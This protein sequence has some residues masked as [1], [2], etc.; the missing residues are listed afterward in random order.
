MSQIDELKK[1]NEA[2]KTHLTMYRKMLNENLAISK[3][4]QQAPP[5][6][7]EQTKTEHIRGKTMTNLDLLAQQSRLNRGNSITVSFAI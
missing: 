3:P 7:P 5:N 1:Q 2:L 4:E 6:K